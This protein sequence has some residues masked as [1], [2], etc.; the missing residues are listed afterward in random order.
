MFTA[1]CQTVLTNFNAGINQPRD[2]RTR[3]WST[4]VTISTLSGVVDLAH[5]RRTSQKFVRDYR[6]QIENAQWRLHYPALPESAKRFHRG[7]ERTEILGSLGARVAE[8]IH[9]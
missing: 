7:K 6:T 5:S 4:R 1:D 2:G 9:Y 8:S 3:A